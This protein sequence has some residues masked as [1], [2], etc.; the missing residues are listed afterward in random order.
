MDNTNDE[1]IEPERTSHESTAKDSSKAQA[2]TSQQAE[3][4]VY[5]TRLALLNQTNSR[6][7]FLIELKEAT[8]EQENLF[9]GCVIMRENRHVERRNADGGRF[10]YR[11]AFSMTSSLR[12]TRTARPLKAVAPSTLWIARNKTTPTPMNFVDL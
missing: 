4:I 3:K 2:V 5:E 11:R 12:T 9:A 6:T 7:E 1:N 8:K 10:A